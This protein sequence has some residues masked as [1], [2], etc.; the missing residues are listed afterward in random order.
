M[1]KFHLSVLSQCRFYGPLLSE[2]TMKPAAWFL[3]MLPGVAEAASVTISVRDGAGHPVA[4]AVVVLEVPGS[5]PPTPRAAAYIMSQRDIAFDPHTLIVPVGA[6]V[7]FPN[8]DKV[9]HHVYSFSKAKRFELKLYGREDTRAVTFDRPGPVALGCNIHDRMNGLIYV[10]NSRFAAVT[11]ASGRVTLAGVPRARA[12]ILVWDPS[13]RA[14]GN[15]L[16]QPIEVP[17]DG[18]VSAGVTVR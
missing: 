11:D 17:A 15:V 9:R 6:T 3:L 13:I 4:D 1:I 14:A 2:D 10:T 18:G 5:L 12:T 16:R 7:T 8:R